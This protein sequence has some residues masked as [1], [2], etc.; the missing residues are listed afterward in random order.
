MIYRHD[1]G[2]IAI[3][4]G[5]IIRMREAGKRRGLRAGIRHTGIWRHGRKEGPAKETA[6][7]QH[8]R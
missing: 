6:K 5:D 7:E 2:Y 8:T 3:G 4:F 1:T